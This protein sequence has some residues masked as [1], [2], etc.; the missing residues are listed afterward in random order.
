[1]K[2][3]A[4]I[5]T[6]F[7]ILSGSVTASDTLTVLR[8][9][10]KV[11]LTGYTRHVTTRT[12]SAEISGKVS[13]VNYDIGGQVGSEP[14]IELDTTFIKYQIRIAEQS[15]DLAE[16]SVKQARA[17]AAYLRK[18]ASRIESLR[19]EDMVSESR[20]DA[21]IRDLNLAVLDLEAAL[22]E[23]TVLKTELD[24]LLERRR[25]H[26]IYAPRGWIVTGRN[27][28]ETENVR[29]GV[30]LARVSD[31]SELVVP[32]Y[33]SPEELAA[34]RS[35]PAVFNAEL[36]G[37]PVTASI[38]WVNPEFVEKTRKL[39]IKLI[40][41]KYNGIK[42]GG[43]KLSLPVHLKTEGL[44]IP[45]AAVSMRYENPTVTLKDT[46]EKVRLIILGSAGDYLIAADDVRLSPGTVLIPAAEK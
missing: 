11:V 22:S 42:I 2:Y 36:E 4:L 7:I 13:K 19:K 5:L 21:I 6:C 12:V 24:E 45:G 29:Q 30:P 46:G 23:R 34:I 20:R 41:R 9:A 18:E 17:R 43:L 38:K 28:E 3:I 10:R 26:S 33:V 1:M 37:A 44:Y 39:G 16:V 35:L 8:A 25:R 14:F 40:I 32:L 31:Y 27:V 15:L